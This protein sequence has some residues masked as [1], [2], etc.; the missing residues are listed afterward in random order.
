VLRSLGQTGAGSPHDPARGLLTLLL[1][2]Q[3]IVV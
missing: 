3:L 1:F 2:G